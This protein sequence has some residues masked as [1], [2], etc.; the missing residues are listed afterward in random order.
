MDRLETHNHAVWV[1]DS[2]GALST[3]PKNLVITFPNRP[4]SVK[5]F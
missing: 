4:E 5:Q 3:Y 2:H 1:V